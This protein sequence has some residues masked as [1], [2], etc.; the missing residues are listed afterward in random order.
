MILSGFNNSEG[1]NSMIEI[2]TDDVF[3][4]KSYDYPMCLLKKFQ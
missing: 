3:Y 2:D 1:C 4:I